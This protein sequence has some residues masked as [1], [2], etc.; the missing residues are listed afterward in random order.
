MN[1]YIE[2]HSS[3]DNSILIISKAET[4]AKAWEKAIG[5]KPWGHA[6]KRMKKRYYSIK[7]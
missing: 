2:T 4:E 3:I 7:R 1:Y 6:Q 5:L